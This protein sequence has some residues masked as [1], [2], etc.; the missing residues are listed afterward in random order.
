MMGRHS[1]GSTCSDNEFYQPMHAFTMAFS[2]ADNQVGCFSVLFT[3]P[4]S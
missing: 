2:M 1:G 3:V 4:E